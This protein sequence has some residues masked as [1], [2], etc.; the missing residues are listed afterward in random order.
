MT[1]VIKCVIIQNKSC[2]MLKLLG[3][4]MRYNNYTNDAIYEL[5]RQ[6]TYNYADGF[7]NEEESAVCDKCGTGNKTIFITDSHR[8]CEDCICDTLR[9]SFEEFSSQLPSFGIDVERIFKNI[10]EDFSDSEL[11]SYVENIYE[12]QQ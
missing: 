4:Q 2:I 10:T 6:R 5:E 9:D 12:K 3:G 8:L 7:Y 1:S 11:L